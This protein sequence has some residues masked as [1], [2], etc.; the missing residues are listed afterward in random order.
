MRIFN[1]IVDLGDD[2]DATVLLA[3]NILV[4]IHLIAFVALI[5]VVCS[6]M[7]KSN[8]RIFAEGVIKMQKEVQ[9][10]NKKVNKNE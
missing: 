1:D 4:G 6:N 3:L 9:A 2:L 10:K 7:F 5:V 8:D